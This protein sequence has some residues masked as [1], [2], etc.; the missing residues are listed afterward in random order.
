LVMVAVAV[1]APLYVFFG[2]LS[3]KVGRKWVL[4]FGMT[5]ALLAFFPGFHLMAKYANPAL[6]EAEVRMPVNVIADPATCH[7]QFDPV[8]K[9]VFTSSCDIAKSALANAGVSYVNEVGPP[10][11]PARV[12]VGS[13]EVISVEGEGLD[14]AG[15]KAAK[16][17]FDTR[18]KAALATAGYPAKADV[19]R[20]DIAAL[21]GVMMIFVV[22]A[23]ALYGPQASALVELFPTRVRYTALSLPYHV[24]TGWVGGFVPFTAFAIVAAV[25]DIYSGL[26]YPFAFTA[27]SVV[28]CLLFLPETNKRSL[29]D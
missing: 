21:F 20:M 18:L 25:G 3:D 23:T 1:S 9:A 16:A 10:G 15:L 8:G 12:D 7:L 4:W 28:T 11:V 6:Q 17:D 27:I 22:A 2:W 13:A 19:S 14:K 24:G 5:L 29:H 26:W